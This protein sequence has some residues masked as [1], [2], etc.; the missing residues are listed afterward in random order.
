MA[1][2]AG[3][4][5]EVVARYFGRGHTNGDVVIYFP[6]ERVLHTG[7]LFTNGAPFCDTSANCNIKKWDNTIQKALAW[8]FD[9]VAKACTAGAP[10]DA[11]KR[12]DLSS[13]NLQPSAN[14]LRSVPGM[15]KEL[16]Q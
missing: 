2:W 14:F 10:E 13:V 4:G 12:V 8:G 5:K 11:G 1:R 7:D 3:G 6:S 16:A 9:Q 15:C